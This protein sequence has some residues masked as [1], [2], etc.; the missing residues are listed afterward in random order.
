MSEIVQEYAQSLKELTF[1]SRPIIDTLTTIAAE[2]T[3]EGDG[4]LDVI[5]ARIY[6]CLPEQKL[7]ALYLLDSICKNVGNPYNIL[8]GDDI[9]KLFSHVYLLVDDN[10]RKKL[11]NLFETWRLTKA[12]GTNIPLFPPG[13]LEKIGAF[14]KKAGPVNNGNELSNSRLIRD[15]DELLPIFHNKLNNNS[16]DTKLN[17]RFNA[18][19][20]LK[21]LL[22]NQKM[23]PNELKAVEAQLNTIKHQELNRSSTSAN[24]SP[25]STP[26]L[27]SN[28][29]SSLPATPKVNTVPASSA[30][31]LFDRLINEGIITFEQDFNSPRVYEINY[32]KGNPND[33][34]D[35]FSSILGYQMIRSEYEQLKYNEL[36]KLKVTSQSVQGFISSP[37]VSIQCKN[38][39]Y[40]SKGLKCSIC[41]KRFNTDDVGKNRKRLHLDWHFRISQKFKS[42]SNVQSR[43]WYLDDVDWAKFKDE[44]LLEFQVNIANSTQSSSQFKPQ[45][46]KEIPYVIIPSTETNMNNKCLICREQVKG[47][48]NEELGEWCWYNCI[49]QPGEPK[50]SRKIVHANC[51]NETRKRGA[52]EDA[53]SGLKR[54]RI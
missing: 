28:I 25:N 47:S 42:S 37:N 26:T 14:L 51:Y 44:N 52:L 50:G 34:S 43:S 8:I 38:L 1:N 27:R 24:S 13:E 35:V 12:K 6:K 15:I 16:N 41:G 29:P 11:Q 30:N 40:E 31:D 45:E 46:S 53:H 10:V 4:I 19:N 22:Q 17:E 49:L 39:L 9:F 48:F 2:N 3:D 7:F 18:L 5:T 54:E 23:Q 21:F 33:H 36:N 20:Q 32:P